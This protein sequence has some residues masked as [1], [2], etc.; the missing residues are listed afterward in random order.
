VSLTTLGAVSSLD[1]M[2]K[3]D[4]IRLF[5]GTRHQDLA[6]AL[7][8]TRQLISSWPQELTREQED[9]VIGAWMRR[10]GF[11]FKRDQAA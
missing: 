9:R 4:A 3:H 5:G 2:T 1:A 11:R 8:V 7:G 10:N 6:D